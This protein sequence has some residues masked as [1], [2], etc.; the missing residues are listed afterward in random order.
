MTMLSCRTYWK[1][2]KYDVCL[3]STKCLKNQPPIIGH[4][5]RVVWF[6]WFE[7]IVEGVGGVKRV[8][9]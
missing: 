7:Q 9:W 6:T 3:S 8:R 1:N 4:V 5:F 2:L